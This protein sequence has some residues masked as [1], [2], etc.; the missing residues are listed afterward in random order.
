M[1]SGKAR[2]T[3]CLQS[4][5]LRKSVYRY[6]S[7]NN[8]KQTV[9]TVQTSSSPQLRTRWVIWKRKSLE[10][11]VMMIFSRTKGLMQINPRSKLLFSEAKKMIS[12]KI[13]MTIDPLLVEAAS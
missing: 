11:T 12:S 13:L 2:C 1:N 3:A 4:A 5:F 8:P 6:L 9:Q 7:H 10:Q